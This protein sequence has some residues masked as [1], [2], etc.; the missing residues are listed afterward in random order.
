M[1][2]KD[3]INHAD[4]KPPQ[5]RSK[6]DTLAVL[7][8]AAKTLGKRARSKYFT[9]GVIFPLIDL[10]SPL[11]K[12]YWNSFHCS[13]VLF[14]SGQRLTTTYCNNR[15]CIVCNRI[16]TAKLIK[17]YYPQLQKL[18]D[19]RFLTLT[20]ETVKSDELKDEIE[21]KLKLF[22]LIARRAKRKGYK[23]I[24]IRKLEV[25]YN[26]EKDWY[27][28]HLHAIIQGEE[29]SSFF[30]D[31]WLKENAGKVDKQAQKDI[32]VNN[33]NGYIELFKYSVKMID[34]RKISAKHLDII[35]QAL[36]NK[37]T[38]YPYGIKRVSE[39]VEDIQSEEYE[40]LIENDQMWLWHEKDWISEEG[41][42]LTGYT[43]SEADNKLL[44]KSV[45]KA[46][47]NA[48][49][50]PKTNPIYKPLNNP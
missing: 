3:K 9:N 32:P 14:Q 5:G 42:L 34:S 35:Y 17:G 18:T 21:R 16:R 47:I 20:T 19:A 15:W 38:L 48:N 41:E 43:P 12:S 1:Q 10:D 46:V 2:N 28:P 50:P 39:E 27:H 31:E 13:A 4:I 45:I 11:K 30:I 26:A 33:E 49:T 7:D 37:N 44:G 22:S 40:D 29:V 24:G 36:R 25:T 23:L 8:Q 6:L